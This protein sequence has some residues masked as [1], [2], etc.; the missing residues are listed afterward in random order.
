MYSKPLVFISDGV[1]KIR[2]YHSKPYCMGY[3]INTVTCEKVRC[4]VWSN[5]AKIL[6]DAINYLVRDEVVA[7][8]LYSKANKHEFKVHVQQ[9]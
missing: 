4:Y 1:W 9:L 6:D 3:D 7:R 8:D 5:N 2:K